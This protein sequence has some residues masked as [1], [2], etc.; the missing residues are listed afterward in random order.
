MAKIDYEIYHMYYHNIMDIEDKILYVR[1]QFHLKP[2]AHV[3][4]KNK[5]EIT[6]KNVLLRK[7]FHLKPLKSRILV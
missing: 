1:K 3:C 2:I 5:K 4:E 7:P 6:D